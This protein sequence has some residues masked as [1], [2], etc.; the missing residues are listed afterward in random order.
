VTTRFWPPSTTT[1]ITFLVFFALL[2]SSFLTLGFA[3][4]VTQNQLDTDA[5]GQIQQEHAKMAGIARENGL[6][7][8]INEIGIDTGGAGPVAMLLING[9]GKRIA[10]D[11]TNWPQGL[12]NGRVV[13]TLLDRRGSPEEP[14]LVRAEALPDGH[15]LL[16]GRNL[17]EETRLL[18]TLTTSLVAGIG[19]A[20]A[21]AGILT[22]FLARIIAA[23]V[24]AIADVAS[25]VAGGDL[26]QRVKLVS[27]GSNDAFD[28]MATSINVMLAR[29]ETLLDELRTVTDGLAHDLRSPLTRLR[30]RI[31]R[32]ARSD[33]IGQVGLEEIGAIGAEADALLAMLDA[34]LEI[35]RV[36]AG[37]GRESFT[38]IDLAALVQDMAE[39]YEPLAEDNGVRLTARTGQPVMLV[40]H[41]ALLG[42]AI[43][44]LI[45]N[46][47]KYA[48][49][50]KVIVLA[51]ENDLGKVRF[52]VSD[53]GPGIAETKRKSALRRFGRLDAART[54]RGAGLGL[55]LA[56]AIARLHGGVL[57]LQDNRPGLR[58]MVEM[59]REPS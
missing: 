12:E 54:E 15:R 4:R 58:V 50:G 46:A 13:R 35:S 34:S 25:A 45:D 44:N 43:A 39:M 51:A 52:S 10:G 28:G 8:V 21:L 1:R 17:A 20:M 48:T 42:R 40:A 19:L 56:A 23:R 53:R 47:L 22:G 29:I 6:R 26:S 16:I 49:K 2:V 32:V 33:S 5:R 37:I 3:G 31:D 36:E 59:P 27:P 57:S 11:I 9:R 18:S 14:F 41:R 7:A 55:S 30:A 38:L 24:Q